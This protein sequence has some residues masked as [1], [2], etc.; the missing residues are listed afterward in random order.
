MIMEIENIPKSDVFTIKYSDLDANIFSD[1]RNFCAVS[2]D[3]VWC[4][5][6]IIVDHRNNLHNDNPTLQ[7]NG[8]YKLVE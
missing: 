2:S 6:G 5:V 4:C 8:V 7:V 3:G 1:D